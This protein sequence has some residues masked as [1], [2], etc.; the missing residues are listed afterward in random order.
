MA[1]F[2]LDRFRN[3]AFG[4]PAVP[5]HPMGTVE[6]ADRLL[7]LLPEDDPG[8]A[9]AELTHW[10]AT[11]NATDSFTPGRRGRILVRLHEAARPLWRELGQRYLAPSGKPDESGSHD[12]SLLRAMSDSASEFAAGFALVAYADARGSAWVDEHLADVLV[13]GMRWLSRRLALAY[14]LHQTHVPAIWESLH[15]LRGLADRHQAFR[16][17]APAFEGGR[18]PSSPMAEYVRALLLELANP[19]ALRPRDVELVYRI[20][21]RV[22]NA[23]RLE[24]K[25][26]TETNFSVVPSGD[27][28][29]E[30]ANRDARKPK[31]GDA[32]YI[33]TVNCLPR[34]RGML[35]RDLGRDPAEEDTLFGRGYTIRER[36]A[37]L[38]R[39]LDYWGMDP[40]RRR[41]KRVGMAAAARLIAGFE[42]VVG[43]LPAAE[44]SPTEDPSA[45]RRALQLVLDDSS[46]TLKR[47]KIR[48]ARVGAGR[49]IDASAGGLGIAIRRVDAPWAAHGAL[50]AILIEPSA[51]W[52]LG[53]L[54]RVFAIEDELRLGIQVLAARPRVVTLR[55]DHEVRAGAWDEAVRFEANFAEH[56]QRGILLEPQPL[57]LAAAELLL[58][59][60]LATRGTQFSVPLPRERA[61]RI[62]VT[63]L[64]EDTPHFQ[65]ALFE[66]LA[67]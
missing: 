40:P 54:R 55:T 5:D 64:A 8:Y 16:T 39:A 33:S 9:L 12:V 30:I 26:D 25:Q 46:S 2:D 51:D 36:N 11:M 6:E 58:R 66:P 49:V 28:R 53:V 29:P 20:A 38:K 14:M 61:Q 52:F 31:G 24:S 23:V 63:R 17:V 34:L 50:L 65:R 3:L 48:A 57:P 4:R 47:D 59:P 27:A 60:R 21:A 10:T 45:G 18:H 15:H 67:S 42:N 56:F 1:L 13:R 19:S 7:A 62:R 41:S 35:E 22:A 44:R 32:L 37:M 43:V